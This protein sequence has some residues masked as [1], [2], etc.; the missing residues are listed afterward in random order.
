MPRSNLKN[1]KSKSDSK[2]SKTKP[3]LPKYR[4]GSNTKTKVT[5][6]KNL[7]EMKSKIV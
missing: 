4:A 7:V 6:I 1:S 5:Q 2:S 3:D